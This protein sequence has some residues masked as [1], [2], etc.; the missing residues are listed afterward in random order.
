MFIYC[1]ECEK[2]IIANLVAGD[3]VYP[4]RKDL[5]SL[6]FWRC[7]TCKNFVG[8]HANSKNHTPLGIIASKELKNARIHIHRI[9]DPLYRNGKHSRR[10]L[11]NIISKECGWSYHTAKIKS[12]EEARNIYKIIRN[13]AR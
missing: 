5:Y 9:L 6:K 1:V 12:V 8:A 2:D 11:Y 10:N 4:H 13:I 7:D 3:V